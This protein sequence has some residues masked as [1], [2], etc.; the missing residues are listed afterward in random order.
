MG[1]LAAAHLQAGR[2]GG[3]GGGGAP[4]AAGG[5]GVGRI[6][7]SLSGSL[8]RGLLSLTGG[9]FLGLGTGLGGSGGGGGGAAAGAATTTA[10][11]AAAAAAVVTA[12][13]PP[14]A[15]GRGGGMTRTR[16][17][18]NANLSFGSFTGL[19][20]GMRSTALLPGASMLPPGVGSGGGGV[21]G[22]AGGAGAAP[23]TIGG[24]GAMSLGDMLRLTQQQQQR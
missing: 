10:A 2:A 8:T 4:P 13:P 22:G 15:G 11:A 19:L 1:A 17:G 16:S 6:T 24:L 18:A 14:A 3:G 21:G 20:A 7:R 9:S 12:G 23:G 5:G